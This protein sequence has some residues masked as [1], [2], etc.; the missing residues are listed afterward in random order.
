[1][2]RVHWSILTTLGL[3]PL[4]VVRQW[5]R[6]GDPAKFNV[7]PPAIVIERYLATRGEA[8]LPDGKEDR[9]IANGQGEALLALSRRLGVNAALRPSRYWSAAESA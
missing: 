9:R 3:P 6:G 4:F 7:I 2:W 1:M 5:L 8:V